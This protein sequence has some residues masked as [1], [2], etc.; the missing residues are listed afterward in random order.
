MQVS[1]K[2]RR[3]PGVAVPELS[4]A[5]IYFILAKLLPVCGSDDAKW[6][7]KQRE[8]NLGKNK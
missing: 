7:L 3:S 2:W 5:G 8:Q 1:K 4:L 6:D